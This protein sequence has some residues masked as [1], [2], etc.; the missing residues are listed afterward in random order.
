MVVSFQVMGLK[1]S[2]QMALNKGV[3]LR[4]LLGR[5]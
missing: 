5:K 2:S 1:D 3:G 4:L